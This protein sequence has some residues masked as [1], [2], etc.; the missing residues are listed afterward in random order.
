MGVED[1][2][3]GA[4]YYSTLAEKAAEEKL[5]ALYADLAAQERVHLERFQNL[6]EEL[7]DVHPAESHPDEYVEYLRAMLNTRAF[8]DAEAATQRALELIDDAAASLALSIRFERDTVTLMKEL[9]GMVPD[10]HSHIVDD[11][12]REEQSHLVQLTRAQEELS[13]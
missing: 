9:E 2:R 11:L 5:R 8:P 7:G 3:T 13:S 6:L 10:R 1:E 4:A 12:I